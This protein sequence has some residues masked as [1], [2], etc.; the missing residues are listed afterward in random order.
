MPN[1]SQD[2]LDIQANL[3][4]GFTLKRVRDMIRTYSQARLWV[5]RFIWSSLKVVIVNISSLGANC[6]ALRSFA[7]ESLLTVT[8]INPGS[9]RIII[10]HIYFKLERQL[11][12]SHIRSNHDEDDMLLIIQESAVFTIYFKHTVFHA[13]ILIS[14]N[15]ISN[16]L[17]RENSLGSSI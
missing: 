13:K 5:I 14:L 7:V 4:C 10:C 16:A 1:L 8:E 17:A 15:E 11:I 6:A 2:F 9:S 12:L 3:E